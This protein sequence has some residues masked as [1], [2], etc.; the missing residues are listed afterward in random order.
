MLMVEITAAVGN[1]DYLLAIFRGI[2]K[3]I[4]GSV[5][6]KNTTPINR[7]QMD[8]APNQKEGIHMI[9]LC[10]VLTA[11]GRRMRDVIGIASPQG[12]VQV[13][14]YKWRLISGPTINGTSL[15]DNATYN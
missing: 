12:A 1:L 2:K 10:K 13:M 4:T 5:Q 14:E 15:D 6:I 3:E 11:L 7:L 8:D 9:I